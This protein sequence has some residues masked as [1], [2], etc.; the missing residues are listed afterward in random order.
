[1][2]AFV[3][4]IGRVR[5]T[6]LLVVYQSMMKMPKA[7]TIWRACIFGWATVIVK[8]YPKRYVLYLHYVHPKLVSDA[9]TIV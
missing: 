4:R 1:M 8:M 6:L 5:G 2:R 9:L 7:G 3:K